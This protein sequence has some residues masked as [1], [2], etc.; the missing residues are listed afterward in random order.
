MAQSDKESVRR[1]GGIPTVTHA[2]RVGK[3]RKVMVIGSAGA[4][5]STFSTSLGEI[6]DLPVYH[7]DSIFWQPGWVK[8][9]REDWARTQEALVSGDAWILDGNYGSTLEI[10]V[11]ACDT[12]I[13]LA[14]SRWLCL[15]RVIKRWLRWRGRTRPDLNSG[16]VEYMPDW[17]FLT[18]IWGYPK[19][20]A[21][22]VLGLLEKYREGRQVFVIESPRE[23]ERFVRRVK[24]GRWE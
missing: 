22:R 1:M 12:V 2:P 24:R 9:E 8:T 4:G 13:F 3:M 7:L 15:A 20:S 16:C 23:L 18:W 6:L 14:Y 5:K 19:T 21:P 10:R 11:R 17:E